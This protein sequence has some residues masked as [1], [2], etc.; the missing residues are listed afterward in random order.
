MKP[1]NQASRKSWL[2][3]VLPAMSQPGISAFRAV[4]MTK[5]WCIMSFIIATR[6]GIDH[7]AEPAAG[8]P[9]IDDLAVARS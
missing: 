2:V 4:P 5:V 1:T 7:P 9:A 8:G 6:A 3:P